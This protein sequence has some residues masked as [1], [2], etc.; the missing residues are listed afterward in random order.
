MLTIPD[1]PL[2]WRSK[3]SPDVKPGDPPVRYPFVFD[4]DR[5]LNLLIERRDPRLTE[6]LIDIYSRPV[7]V[8]YLQDGNNL[9]NNYGADFWRFLTE[10]LNRVKVHNI[11]EIGCGGCVLLEKLKQEGYEVMGFDPSPFAVAAG[12]R[13][14]IRVIEGFFTPEK[15]DIE[16]DLIFEVDVLEHIEDPL[17][18][19]RT[20]TACLKEGG[21]IVVNV[22]DC[23][24]SI[25]RGDIS[26]AL[27][28][29]VNMF[30]VTSLPATLKAA[31]LEV[32]SL[33]QSRYGSALYCAARKSANPDTLTIDDD[34]TKWQ[35]Y[36]RYAG[37]AIEKFNEVVGAARK[38]GKSIGFFMPQR[39]F[40]YLSYMDWFDG[41]RVF[42]NMSMWH[43]RYLD[44]LDVKIENQKDLVKNPVDHVFIMSLTF[45][46]QVRD[47]LRQALPDMAITTLDQILRESRNVSSNN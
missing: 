38:Q 36:C 39:A 9:V 13:K 11:L 28:Q 19:L 5:D 25:T 33:E 47:E 42:D 35:Q 2:Y 3:D 27:H 31:G 29:H 32:I 43:Q 8:G 26:M 16:P 37:L 18:F 22:P 1:M 21:V 7:N 6:L 10:V 17:D 46:D 45:G 12:T 20:Q 14:N 41:F 23:T 44:G 24:R 34:D 40:P 4:F 15:L 30:D